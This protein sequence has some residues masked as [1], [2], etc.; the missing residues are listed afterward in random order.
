[1]VGVFHRQPEGHDLGA[2]VLEEHR[3]VLEFASMNT[4]LIDP[5]SAPSA[6]TVT[7]G[8]EL[9]ERDTRNQGLAK[10]VKGVIA[11]QRSHLPEIERAHRS[12]R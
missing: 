5:R 6:A 2:R 12:T 7:F 10:F 11:M 1:M 9:D 3:A 8:D 4:R